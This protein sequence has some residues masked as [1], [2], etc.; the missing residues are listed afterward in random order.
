MLE[1]IEGAREAGRGDLISWLPGRAGALAR[2]GHRVR[3][4]DRL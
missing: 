1:R 4:R 3:E 2:A